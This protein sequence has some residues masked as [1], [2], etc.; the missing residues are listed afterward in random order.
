[1]DE[2]KA[3]YLRGERYDWVT[4]PRR[5]ERLYH[6]RRER[7][8]RRL[9]ERHLHSSVVVDL[10]CGTG[11]I[12]RHLPPDSLAVDINTWNLARVMEHANDARPLQADAERLPLRDGSVDSLV[13]CEVLE[14]LPH[15][16]AM[17]R[18]C[19]RVLKT[20]GVFIGSVP[21]RHLV[22]RLRRYLLS[23]CPQ[24]EPFHHNYARA[25]LAGLLERAGFRIHLLQRGCWGLNW[26]WVAHKEAPCSR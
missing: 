22:W 5:L 24:S 10:G 13:A 12:T 25:A 16:E 20:G 4:H 3:F 23:T 7:D 15:P 8:T 14:H 2:V 19:W 6:Q 18:E 1:M 17:L 11:L 21:S 9:V 26:L